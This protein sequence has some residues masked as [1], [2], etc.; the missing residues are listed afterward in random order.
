MRRTLLV[1][2][3]ENFSQSN[4]CDDMSIWLVFGIGDSFVDTR[5]RVRK[6][7]DEYYTVI[8]IMTTFA[9]NPTLCT[10]ACRAAKEKKD[11]C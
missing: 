8:K 7:Y 3:L 10:E 5:I 9:F 1:W 2:G 4:S 6:A 11:L